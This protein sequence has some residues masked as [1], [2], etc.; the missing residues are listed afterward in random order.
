[1]VKFFYKKRI[2]CLLLVVWIVSGTGICHDEA[3]G[4]GRAAVRI[5]IML[6]RRK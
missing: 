4:T 1:M 5:R 3:S 6:R 2:L